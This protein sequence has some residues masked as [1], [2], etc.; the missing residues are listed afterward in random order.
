M[1]LF[2][3]FFSIFKACLCYAFISVNIDQNFMLDNCKRFSSIFKALAKIKLRT[4]NKKIF[5]LFFLYA[6][7][8]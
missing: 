2:M 6:I 8:E 4:L 1:N 5:T 3:T 7:D